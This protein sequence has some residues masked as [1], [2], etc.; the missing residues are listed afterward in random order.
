MKKI[1]TIILSSL[2]LSPVVSFAASTS[3]RDILVGVQGIVKMLIPIS[4]GIAVVYFF[5][6]T[7]QFILHADD[8]KTH[9]YGKQKMIWGVVAITVIFSIA[10]IISLIGNIIGTDCVV[11]SPTDASG[12]C[13][14]D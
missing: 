10:G 14:G 11:G 13:T 5:W 6:G 9:E 1:Y 8:E 3:V 7:S 12:R 2:L 4:A